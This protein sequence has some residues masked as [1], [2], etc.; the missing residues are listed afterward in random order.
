MRYKTFGNTGLQVSVIGAG[1]WGMGGNGWDTREKADLIAALHAMVDAGVNLIDTAPAYGRGMAEEIVGEA[2]AGIR[3]KLIITTKCGMNIDKPGYAV[4]T[5]TRDEVI[6]GCEGSMRRMKL[7]RIDILLLHWPD[8]NTPLRETMEAMQELK[9]RGRVRFI[10]VSNLPKER[11]EEARAYADITVTQL[12]YSMV[13]LS[14]QADIEWAGSHGI[15]TMTYGSMGAGILAGGM[16]KHTE[17]AKGDVRG[18]FYGKIYSEPMFSRVMTLLESMDGVAQS[19]GATVAQVAV[20]WVTQQE[21]VHT[22]LVGAR[23]VAHARDTCGAADWMLTDDE[24]RL[25]TG[26]TNKLLR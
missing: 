5:A 12:P 23:T 24:M 2:I 1:T 16:R 22:A 8:E 13:D 15:A 14:A 9:D 10:G 7:D 25:L 20:N 3:D 18:G 11:M 19:H 4:K 6:R 21:C 26:E 17:F